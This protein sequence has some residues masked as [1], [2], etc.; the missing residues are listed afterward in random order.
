[1]ISEIDPLLGRQMCHLI[2]LS[3]EKVSTL[4]GK[5][6]LPFGSKFFPFRVDCFPEG[7]ESIV[8]KQEITKLFSWKKNER[9]S[10]KRI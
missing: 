2:C 4:K 9:K 5:N 7:N 3:S 6:L 1:M 10:T 8:F